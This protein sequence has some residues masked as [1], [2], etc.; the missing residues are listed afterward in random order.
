MVRLKL[1]LPFIQELSQRKIGISEILRGHNLDIAS[2]T[3]SDHLIPAVKLYQLVEQMAV[4]ANDRFLA[5]QIGEKL[6]IAAWPA[7][8]SAIRESSTL[9]EFIVRFSSDAHQQASSIRIEL[10]IDGQSARFRPRRIFD[11]GFMPGQVDAFYVGLFV[12]MFRNCTGDTWDPSSVLV[13]TSVPDA[14]P[15]NYRDLIITK[16]DN[17]GLTIR[18]PQVWLTLPT[19]LPTALPIPAEDRL[20]GLHYESPS[21]T[22]IHALRQALAS[23]VHRSDLTVELAASICGI[24]QRRLS[25]H[26]K[27]AGTT[28]KREIDLLRKDQAVKKLNQTKL[29]VAD[30]GPLVGYPDP[31]AFSRAFKKWTGLPPRDYRKK[32]HSIGTRSS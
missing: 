21:N 25:A 20:S 3:D 5:L 4:A 15:F 26:L 24:N 27:K 17:R 14:I 32:L 2:F 31:T 10:Q 9:G 22:L 13:K 23:H 12:T 11:P 8:T 7:F 16:G 29:S 18:F 19:A 1:L 6:D 30:I 28:L